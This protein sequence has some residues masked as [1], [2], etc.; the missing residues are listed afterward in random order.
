M[1]HATRVATSVFDQLLRQPCIHASALT[2]RGAPISR[3]VLI[4]H[5]AIPSGRSNP[6]PV[7]ITRH[8]QDNG[9]CLRPNDDGSLDGS[10][11]H[12]WRANW[13]RETPLGPNAPGRT[14]VQRYR[15]SAAFPTPAIAIVANENWHAKCFLAQS[16]TFIHLVTRLQQLTPPIQRHRHRKPPEHP[17]TLDTIAC[18]IRSK[19]PITEN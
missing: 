13:Q 18:P 4:G 5:S 19:T 11:P 12:V 8:P 9:Q 15:I 1:R 3:S 17:P 2:R 10:P 14:R 7:R 16:S 6:Q